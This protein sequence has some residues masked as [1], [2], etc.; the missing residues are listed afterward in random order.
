[1][2][3]F[4]ALN[5]KDTDAYK[6]VN[7]RLV[8]LHLCCTMDYQTRLCS[9]STRQLASDLGLTHKAVRCA[10]NALL[11]ADLLRAQPRA[12]E[13]AHAITYIISS[14]DDIKGT[15]EGTSEDT[16]INNNNKIFSL[17]HVRERFFDDFRVLRLAEYLTC[18]EDDARWHVEHFCT[19]MDIRQKTSWADEVD[20]WQHLLS[21]CDKRKGRKMAKNSAP[22]AP[23]EPTSEPSEPKKAFLCPSIYTAEEWE[24]I[25]NMYASKGHAPCID[26]YYR[27]GIEDLQQQH[28]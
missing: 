3:Y 28:G 13:R 27:R 22:V 24:S 17:A 18:S 8:Y 2:R 5:I 1:M 20:A 15:S 23:S 7:A 6:N 11:T 10:L 16:H 21:W 9:I 19:M 12:Q 4:T 25:C 26:D 14:L